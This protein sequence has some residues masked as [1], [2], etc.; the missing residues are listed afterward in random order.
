MEPSVTLFIVEVMFSICESCYNKSDGTILQSLEFQVLDR[1]FDK[2]NN[3][4]FGRVTVG[5]NGLDP[6]V[7]IAT[8][9]EIYY[10]VGAVTNPVHISGLFF[11]YQMFGFASVDGQDSIL[12]GSLAAGLVDR[13]TK[14]CQGSIMTWYCRSSKG[15]RYQELRGGFGYHHHDEEDNASK[16][17]RSGVYTIEVRNR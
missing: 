8:L 13:L 15:S 1:C 11:G 2:V 6:S 3:Q 16:F 4:W 14:Q 9:A 10:G 5:V 17:Q 12:L 7:S